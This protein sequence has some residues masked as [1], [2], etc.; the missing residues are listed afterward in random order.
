MLGQGHRPPSLLHSHTCALLEPV[1]VKPQG[2]LTRCSSAGV[3]RCQGMAATHTMHPVPSRR[4]PWSFLCQMVLAGVQHLGIGEGSCSTLSQAHGDLTTPCSPTGSDVMPG[5]SRPVHC[6]AQPL[7][8]PADACL[9]RALGHSPR[10]ALPL[11][12]GVR[13][14]GAGGRPVQRQA[15]W[16][17]LRVPRRRKVAGGHRG[18]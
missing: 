17:Q 15:A 1:G 6:A 13:L 12:A 16:L 2:G 7:R 11:H 14:V 4:Q 5:R 3:A 9:S 8:C 10:S 18:G